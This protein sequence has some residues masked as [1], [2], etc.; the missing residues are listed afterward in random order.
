[1]DGYQVQLWIY[2]RALCDGWRQVTGRPARPAGLFYFPVRNEY[3]DDRGGD[4]ESARAQAA[5]MNGLCL[6]DPVALA[7]MD[8]DLALPTPVR[9]SWA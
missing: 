8:R 9:P 3:T 4:P 7:A 6:D 5:R 2:L 1:M